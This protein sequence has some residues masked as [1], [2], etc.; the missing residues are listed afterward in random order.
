MIQDNIL[1]IKYPRGQMN[2]VIN[3]F[4]P[5]TLEKAR[6]VFRLMRDHST[7][8]DIRAMA[9][10]YVRKQYGPDIPCPFSV[11]LW[12]PGM[13]GYNGYGMSRED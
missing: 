3:R 8:E 11:R 4:F 10:E 1:Q 6:L 9:A 7:E 2:L 5:A 12:H 13:E